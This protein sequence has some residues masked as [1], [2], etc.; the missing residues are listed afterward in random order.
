M[1]SLNNNDFYND[2]FYSAPLPST[3]SHF[4]SSSVQLDLDPTATSEIIMAEPQSSVLISS[5][6]PQKRRYEENSRSTR[7]WRAKDYYDLIG[8]HD[9]LAKCKVCSNNGKEKIFKHNKSTSN[10]SR[11]LRNE[12]NI[13]DENPDGKV[14]I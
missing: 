13:T 1:D 6:Q 14:I 12:H 7:I 4:S 2:D 9:E 3:P 11:H 10:L 8:E 5:N